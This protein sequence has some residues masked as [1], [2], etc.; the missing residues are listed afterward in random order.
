VTVDLARR[1]WIIYRFNQPIFDGQQPDPVA[2]E[3][4]ALEQQQQQQSS[5]SPSSNDRKELAARISA[6]LAIHSFSDDSPIEEPKPTR[7]VITP[8]HFLYKVCCVTVSW[9]RYMAVASYYGPPTIEQIMLATK[10][11]CKKESEKVNIDD[12]EDGDDGDGDILL[13]A[14]KIAERFR[15]KQDVA[16]V[17]EVA[18][19]TANNEQNH[20]VVDTATENKIAEED[21]APISEYVNG[22]IAGNDLSPGGK[23]SIASDGTTPK[24]TSPASNFVLNA[25]HRSLAD[26]LVDESESSTD[27]DR[28]DDDAV[29]SE[30]ISH[31]DM[32]A[33]NGN[34]SLEIQ[35]SAS[36]PELSNDTNTPATHK[37][38]KWWKESSRSLH[39]KSMLILRPSGMNDDDAADSSSHSGGVASFLGMG[40]SI[41]ADDPLQ[42]VI[43]LDKP[44]LLCQEIYTR[45]IGNHQ[46]SKVSKEKVLTL[47]RQDMEQHVHSKNDDDADLANEH[48]DLVAAVSA[49][50][51]TMS[52]KETKDEEKVA[53]IDQIAGSTTV[54][55]A[56]DKGTIPLQEADNSCPKEEKEG[57]G[58]DKNQNNTSS[59]IDPPPPAKEQPLVGYWVWENTL[60][61]HKMKMHLAKGSDLALHVVLAVLV[62]QLRYERNAIA[63]AV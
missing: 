27:V 49:D 57:N 30:S 22:T 56:N 3:K 39:E 32:C 1:Y 9:S 18:D 35:T 5:N 7:P 28:F 23:N 55:T 13:E 14:A 48:S 33:I 40:K 21:P 29:I 41:V 8:K 52:E 46:T 53:D 25:K 26:D 17:V 2:T 43:H 60:R 12:D 24:V 37:L 34:E 50:S 63:I 38:H 45:I 62:N 4:F 51:S 44:L 42:G 16:D 15:E 47:L 36:M 31:H 11:A 6:S 61:T 59:E 10:A 19:G 58:G 54:G 20:D